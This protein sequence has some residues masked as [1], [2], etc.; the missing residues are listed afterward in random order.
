M[1][2]VCLFVI[3]QTNKLCLLDIL[4]TFILLDIP[5]A[6]NDGPAMVSV[7]QG[8][9]IMRFHSLDTRLAKSTL[10]LHLRQVVFFCI[11]SD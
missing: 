7:R 8:L 11:V 6:L 3:V 4:L 5:C 9:L 1:H 2:N 10:V